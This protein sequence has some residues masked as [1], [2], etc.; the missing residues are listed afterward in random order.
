MMV[1]Y[2][3]LSWTQK[4]T[5]LYELYRLYDSMDLPALWLSTVGLTRRGGDYGSMAL[6]DPVLPYLATGCFPDAVA[7]ME[8]HWAAM[9]SCEENPSMSRE[10]PSTDQIGFDDFGASASMWLELNSLMVTKCTNRNSH[11]V[12]SLLNTPRSQWCMGKRHQAHPNFWVFALVQ[13]D[14]EVDVIARG[15][16][17]RCTWNFWVALVF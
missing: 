13:V 11:K 1:A 14:I 3:W 17:C 6:W 9:C 5:K 7:T 4:S 16:Q 12:H 15:F 10:V 8:D 2:H